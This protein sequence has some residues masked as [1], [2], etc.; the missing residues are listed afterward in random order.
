MGDRSGNIRW[1]DVNSGMSSTF[2]S[3]RGGVRRI[4]FAPV[5]PGDQTRGRVAVLFND[6]TFAIYDL[7]SL[8]VYEDNC[9]EY[10]LKENK[11]FPNV[12]RMNLK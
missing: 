10:V 9:N 5:V 6:H 4:K 1:W 8:L 7:V 3:H 12:F 11:T 2:N